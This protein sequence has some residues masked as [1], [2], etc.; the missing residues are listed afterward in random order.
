MAATIERVPL[1]I[2]PFHAV[3]LAGTLP[4]YLGGLLADYAYWSTFQIE[5]ANFASWLIAGAEVFCGIA[6][7]FAVI[8][9]FRGSRIFYALLLLLTWV[10][11]LI[12]AFMHG[13]DAW[14][15]MPEGLVLSVVVTVLACIA[16]WIGFST[17]RAGVRP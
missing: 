14:A 10:L 16:T 8:G 12:N 11:G 1:G 5:W 7:L 9:A 4:L 2:H 17:L 3:V 6:L 13:K 15:V